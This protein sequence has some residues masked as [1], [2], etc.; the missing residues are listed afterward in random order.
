MTVVWFPRAFS[1]EVMR[2]PQARRGCLRKTEARLCPDASA[3][4]LPAEAD[5]ALRCNGSLRSNVGVGGVVLRSGPVMSSADDACARKS[6][7]RKERRH[8]PS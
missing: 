3:L 2:G 5:I 7:N 1:L 8:Q 4:L 6:Q